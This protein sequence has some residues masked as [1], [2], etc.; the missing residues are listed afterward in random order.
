VATPPTLNPTP[1]QPSEDG[2]TGRLGSASVWSLILNVFSKFQTI[3]LLAAGSIIGGLV[4]VGVIVTASAACVL[5]AALA[6]FGLAG[7]LARLNVAYP[8][9]PTVARSVR[10]TARQAPYALL[11]APAAYILVGPTTGSAAL[12]LA[13]GLTSCFLVG[14]IALTAIL[15]GLGDFR[16]PAIRLGGARL[17]ASAAAVA[18]AA[19][20]P[21]PA[22][23]IGCFGAGEAFGVV[24]MSLSVRDVRSRLTKQDRPEARLQ[25]ARHWFGVAAVTSLVTNQADTLLIASI[26]SPEALG[27]FATASTLENGVATFATSA[28]TPA[29]FR[30]IG[31][32]LAGHVERGAH[33]LRR[34]FTV[35]V[36]LAVVLATLGW[37]VALLAGGSIDKF[38]GLADGDGPAVLG[39]C[40]AAGPMGAVVAICII[41]GAGLG[42][43]RPVGVRQ[44]EVGIC[45]VTAIV[46]GALVA[47]PVGAAA[48][49]IVRDA[50]GVLLTRRLTV[51]PSQP[52][53]SAAGG[54][55]E[56]IAVPPPGGSPAEP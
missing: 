5:G 28:A 22:A 21:E 2:A 52:E 26:L 41:V 30:S 36:G 32:T 40:L 6:S 9:Q 20:K 24:A 11:I 49:T 15:N 25:R 48:G 51:P 39:L 3:A 14:T 16:S 34:A 1:Q 4:G 13:T 35:A 17:V 46:V 37:I 29:A 33:L 10:A 45:A 55:A 19:I 47:G 50:V 8:S 54:V 27:L 44:I 42:R 12:F 43:H 53:R 31:S 56:A 18:V 23:V 7:E 38:A